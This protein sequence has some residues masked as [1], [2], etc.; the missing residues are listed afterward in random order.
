MIFF[1]PEKK[2]L[3]LITLLIA[4]LSTGCTGKDVVGTPAVDFTLSG[5][6]GGQI[7]YSGL[8]GKPVLLYFFASW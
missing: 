7:S 4:V 2:L 6:N 8:K 1:N 5:I 3:I